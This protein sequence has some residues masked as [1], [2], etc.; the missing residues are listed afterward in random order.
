M[1]P[2]GYFIRYTILG[3]VAAII[4]SANI[5]DLMNGLSLFIF[6]VCVGFIIILLVYSLRYD[7]ISLYTTRDWI[8][9]PL[10]AQRKA[11]NPPLG[12]AKDLNRY[13]PQSSYAKIGKG[14]QRILTDKT[15]CLVG[16]GNVGSLA[17]ELLARSGI[18][19]IILVDGDCVTKENLLHSLYKLKDIGKSKAVVLESRLRQMNST[20]YVEGHKVSLEQ[21]NLPILG[22]DLVIDCTNDHGTH[23]MINKYCIQNQM[24]WI[25][26][27][28]ARNRGML[29]VITQQNGCLRCFYDKAIMGTKEIT[30]PSA[31]MGSAIISTLALQIL[32]KQKYD[33][34]LHIFHVSEAK[35]EKIKI[36]KKR[37]CIVCGRYG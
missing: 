6:V 28:F 16:L 3:I 37:S 31:G 35:L 22:S 10:V 11:R 18:G 36:A 8:N 9:P 24:T 21:N 32:L 27:S 23:M 20:V 34:R 25:F 5:S 29:K 13:Y 30:G 2:L 17:A 7:K 1:E 26:S 4:Y 12:K 19:N 15:V 14:G 33:S